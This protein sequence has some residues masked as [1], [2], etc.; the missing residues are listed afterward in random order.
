MFTAHERRRGVNADKASIF[1]SQS[2]YSQKHTVS[3]QPANQRALWAALFALEL[4]NS[5]L[6]KYQTE[7]HRIDHIFC[8]K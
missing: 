7:T 6:C 5:C 8:H 2:K 4:S 3:F 1:L